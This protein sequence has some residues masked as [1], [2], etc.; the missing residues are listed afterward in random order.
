MCYALYTGISLVG[1][2]YAKIKKFIVD[3]ERH[4]RTP[5]LAAISGKAIRVWNV[6]FFGAEADSMRDAGRNLRCWH[7]NNKKRGAGNCM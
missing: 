2:D 1:A 4:R 5:R 6:G 3:A 7:S